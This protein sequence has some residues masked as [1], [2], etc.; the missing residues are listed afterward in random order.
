MEQPK[1]RR[2]FFRRKSPVAGVVVTSIIAFLLF[3][4][5][6]CLFVAKCSL[7]LLSKGSLKSTVTVMLEDTDFRSTVTE[8]IVL[9]APE[10]TLAADQVAEVMEDEKI[11]E[12]IG[13]VGSDWFSEILD[14]ESIDPTD[15]ILK[16]LENPEQKDELEQALDE[17]MIQLDYTD[18]N[19]KEAAQELGVEPPAAE[20]TNLEI[21]SAI[22][23]GSREKIQAETGEVLELVQDVKETA[24]SAFAVIGLISTLLGNAI[25]LLIN[26]CL[27]LILYGLM[28]LLLRS[29]HKPC[30]Y[31]GGPY[32]LVGILMLCIA[33]L[34]GAALAKSFGLSDLAGT[35]INAVLHSAFSTGLIGVI[36]GA[37]LS[38]TAI[39]VTIIIKIIN[40]KK[41]ETP[42]C[43]VPNAEIN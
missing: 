13:Q 21:V 5:V 25:F 22:L 39:T 32:L 30:Y 11:A 14:E 16:A 41:E 4:I 43:S 20:S 1:G 24:G 35:A 26:V 27:V 23:D 29:L 42:V 38:A 33:S 36:V 9:L 8:T 18:E 15:A 3:C 31:L 40:N 17:A 19:L 12:A 37:V 2:G 34:D 28:I 7:G 6:L 10:D